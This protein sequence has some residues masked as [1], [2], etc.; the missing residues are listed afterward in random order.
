MS[1]VQYIAVPVGTAA[2]NDSTPDARVGLVVLTEARELLASGRDPREVLAALRVKWGVKEVIVAIATAMGQRNFIEA[3]AKGR[4]YAPNA[5]P[6][7]AS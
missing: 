7:E 6:E 4:V 2:F 5:S 3:V 1:N